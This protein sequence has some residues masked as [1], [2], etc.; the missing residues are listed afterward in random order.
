VAPDP[1]AYPPQPP[2]YGPSQGQPGPQ[3]TQPIDI[4]A[5]VRRIPRGDGLIAGSL[6]LLFI[7]SFIGQWIRV[8]G[9]CNAFGCDT[10][11]FTYDSLWD[12]FGILPALLIIFA[13]LWF[14]IRAVPQ[15]RASLLLPIPDSLIWMAFAVL[16]ILL[17]LLHWVI[18]NNAANFGIASSMPGWA[19]FCAI[20]FAAALG[21]GG[22]LNY[23]KGPKLVFA[24]GAGRAAASAYAPA[25]APGAASP[26]PAPYTPAPAPAAAQAYAPA[27][28]PA[29][30]PAYTPAPAPVPAPAVTP[31]AAP[32]PVPAAT[33]ADATMPA[34]RVAV[35]ALSPD[36][37]QWFDGSAWRSTAESAP[38]SAPRSDDGV[39]W[40]DGSSWRP[41]PR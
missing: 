16:E 4:A 14:V 32:A 8:V 5:M 22:Y 2:T 11:S 3:Q 6:L 21:V 31:A 40:W 34:V 10:G 41:V 30:A 36:R 29:P 19:A 37:Q 17:F 24:S 27:P 33:A 7:F 13:I 1:P 18:D 12:G 23:Q 9:A 25:P 35:G 15:W 26:A 38:P 20:V 28:A 39:Y